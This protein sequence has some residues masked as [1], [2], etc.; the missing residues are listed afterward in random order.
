MRV[1]ILSSG[2]KDSAAAWWWAIC[3]GW[4]VTTLI[5]MRVT[6]GDSMM[7]QVPGTDIVEYQAKL[8]NVDWISINTEGVED[9]EIYDLEQ[10]LA[11]LNIDALVCGALRSDYQKSRIERMC[12]RIGIISYTPLWHQSALSHITGLVDNGFGVMITSVAC[13]G[14]DESWIGKILD[15]ESLKV[16]IQLSEKYRFNVDGEGGEYETLVVRGPHFDG[17]IDIVGDVKWQGRRGELIINKMS[18]S[19]NG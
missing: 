17:N 2:G 4:D 16:L 8:A 11:K 13:D 7:F 1:G 9:L 5:T 15:Q 3:K 19:L 18:V 6:S 14:L 12:A 10:E